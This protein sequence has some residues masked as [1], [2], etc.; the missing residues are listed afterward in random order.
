M[1][2]MVAKRVALGLA[3][4]VL[5]GAGAS[6]ASAGD[7]RVAAQSAALYKGVLPCAKAQEALDQSSFGTVTQ[8]KA[9]LSR[10]ITTERLCK[11]TGGK[12]T[13]AIK[14][15]RYDAVKA[16]ASTVLSAV[17]SA[18]SSDADTGRALAQIAQGNKTLGLRMLARAEQEGRRFV[19]LWNSFI[20]KLQA[21]GVAA[22]LTPA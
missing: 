11:N 9:F 21:A 15:H 14:A 22:G 4:L 6:A 10:L 3:G 16:P 7:V 1:C 8:Q 20:S 17:R 2:V 13:A 18:V 12:L 19:D 5:L